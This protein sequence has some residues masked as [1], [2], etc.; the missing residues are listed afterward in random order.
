MLTPQLFDEINIRGLARLAGTWYLC[1]VIGC[2]VIGICRYD[3]KHSPH[4]IQKVY[5]LLCQG[6]GAMVSSILYLV[7]GEG[8]PS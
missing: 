8:Y 7:D 1:Y 2:P 6:H 5:S 4:G 3:H